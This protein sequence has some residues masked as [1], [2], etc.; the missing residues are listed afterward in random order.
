MH[1]WTYDGFVSM[2]QSCAASC[3]SLLNWDSS[4]PAWAYLLR[5]TSCESLTLF[6]PGTS[7]SRHLMIGER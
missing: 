7:V 6:L 1:D 4:L 5:M 2:T 3:S